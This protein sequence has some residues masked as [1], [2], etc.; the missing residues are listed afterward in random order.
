MNVVLVLHI[1]RHGI[2]VELLLLAIKLGREGH[3][4]PIKVTSTRSTGFIKWCPLV[5]IIIYPFVWAR[6]NPYKFGTPIPAAGQKTIEGHPDF[7]VE[8]C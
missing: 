6:G 1:P 8:E 2:I 5:Y 4:L 3:G 7:K